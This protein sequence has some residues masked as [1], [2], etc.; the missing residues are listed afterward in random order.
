MW[1]PLAW[2]EPWLM[3]MLGLSRWISDTVPGK[4]QENKIMKN[5]GYINN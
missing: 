5:K 1:N 4:N 2:K 3:M